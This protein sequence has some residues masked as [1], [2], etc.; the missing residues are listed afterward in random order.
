VVTPGAGNVER[1][2][3]ERRVLEVVEGVVAELGGAVL[4]R[5]VRRQ[6][7][8]DRDLGIGSLE[9]V[10]LLLR[11]EQEFRV[12]L[13]DPVMADA[14]SPGD[15]VQAIRDA[16]PGAIERPPETQVPIGPGASAPGDA[17]TLV[18][19][20]RWHADTHP[21]RVHIFLRQEG[22]SCGRSCS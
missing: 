21:Q 10:E 14:E 22:G 8:L 3:V 13:A 1:E 9:R 16:A 7:S 15:L 5:P 2:G 11:L 6:D 4:G 17:L 18:E 20:L 19:V 12:R